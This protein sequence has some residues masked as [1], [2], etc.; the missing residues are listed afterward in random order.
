MDPILLGMLLV[1]PLLLIFMSSKAKKKQ[2]E[3]AAQIKA[4]LQPGVW[5]R[6]GS[7]FYGIVSDVDGS[8]V[9]LHSPDGSET[10]WDIRAIVEVT[11]PPFAEDTLQEDSTPEELQ[12]PESPVQLN[13]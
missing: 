8:V 9:V 7:G 2:A 11:E 1:L 5:V 6:T 3:M 13:D 4:D 12:A 10:L